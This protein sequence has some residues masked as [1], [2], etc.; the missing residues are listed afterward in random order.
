MGLW[1]YFSFFFKHENLI[2]FPFDLI[3]YSNI[4]IHWI[5]F[6]L[7]NWEISGEQSRSW[8]K[9]E[10]KWNEILKISHDK[11]LLWVY[12]KV[13]QTEHRE[14]WSLEKCLNELFSN[15][16]DP[17]SPTFTKPEEIFNHFLLLLFSFS[18]EI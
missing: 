16:D 11:K 15:V 2:Q 17:T 3:I 6:I 14:T 13:D 1:S 4:S 8:E 7:S 9:Q 5:F 18:Y 12:I 10:L